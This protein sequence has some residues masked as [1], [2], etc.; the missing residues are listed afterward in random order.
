M[1][2]PITSIEMVLLDSGSLNAATMIH[3]PSPKIVTRR[4]AS[5]TAQAARGRS[6]MATG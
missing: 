2:I 3:T 4:T 1:T 5:N 6:V